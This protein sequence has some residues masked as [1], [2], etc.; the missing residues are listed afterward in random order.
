VALTTS[1]SGAG[2]A[3]IENNVGGFILPPATYTG[4]GLSAI[5]YPS[6][7]VFFLARINIA[8]VANNT[9]VAGLINQSATPSTS[10]TDGIFFTASSATNMTLQAYSSSTQLWSVAIPSAVLTLYYGNNLWLDLGF[11]YDRLQNVYAFV[12]FPMVGWVPA[13]AWVNATQPPANNGAIAAYQTQ[14]S[15]T[16]TPST[17]AL[18]PAVVF[19]GTAQTA[20]VDFV[21]AAKER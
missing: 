8:A 4:T 19:S 20:R 18:T 14:V 7:K 3:A 10:P 6:K 13:S 16:W 21:M 9:W 5:V 12:G 1:S 17:L 2:T 15:G 11:Y